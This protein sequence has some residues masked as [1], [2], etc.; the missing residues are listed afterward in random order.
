MLNK[1]TKRTTTQE[2]Q[3]RL[4]MRAIPL[5]GDLDKANYIINGD[6]IGQTTTTEKMQELVKLYLLT[7][8]EVI[9]IYTLLDEHLTTIMDSVSL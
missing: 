8:L 2:Y 7:P 3:V 9:D 5:L 1:S 4:L 6:N